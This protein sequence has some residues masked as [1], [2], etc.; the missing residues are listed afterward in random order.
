M[1]TPDPDPVTSPGAVPPAGPGARGR[2]QRRRP[3]A[4]RRAGRGIVV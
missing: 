4:R 1:K 3:G 2:A